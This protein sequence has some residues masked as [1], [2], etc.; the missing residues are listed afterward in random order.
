MRPLLVAA[1]ACALALAL[2]PSALAVDIL[3][4]EVRFGE[5]EGRLL[6]RSATGAV[7]VR[8]EPS[9]LAGGAA[10]GDKPT[11]L[12]RTPRALEATHVWRGIDGIVEIVLQRKD[13]GVA[14]DVIVE[15]AANAGVWVEW[16]A[17]ER[18]VPAPAS[19]P[20]LIAS[21]LIWRRLF[22]RG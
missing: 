18:D 14:I 19:L 6:V 11:D 2:A 13:P 15:D 20:A 16:P 5:T 10:P 21:A 7:S 17:R 4:S 3:P 22:A 8:T 12:A 9:V 1:S